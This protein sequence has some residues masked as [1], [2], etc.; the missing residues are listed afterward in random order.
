MVCYLLLKLVYAHIFLT[1]LALKGRNTQAQ[2][3]ALRSMAYTNQAL[4]GRYNI[5]SFKVLKLML[6][7]FK[8]TR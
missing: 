3:E 8:Y 2:G 1:H 4:K 6:I 5:W 7:I